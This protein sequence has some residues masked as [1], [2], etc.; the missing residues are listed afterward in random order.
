MTVNKSQ[1]RNL[2]LSATISL[3]MGATV[4]SCSDDDTT[5]TY[6]VVIS[7]TYPAEL[8]STY[9][10]ESGT[11][12]YKELNTGRTYTFELPLTEADVLPAGTYDID[13]SMKVSYTNGEGERVEQTLR[14]IASQQVI[15]A[16]AQSASL[17][18]FFYNSTNTLVF[19]EIYCAGSLNAAGTSGLY[20]TFFT[21]YNNTDEVQYAD[22]LALV[23]S[24]L[25]NASTDEIRTPA[26][27]I[28]TNF[29][30][31]TVYVIPGNGHDVAI[32]P[33]E[34]IKIV[35]QAIEWNAQVAGALDHR[36]AD[37][38]W[39]DVV[40]T[41]SVRDTDNPDV[42]NLDK[43]FSYSLT[44]WIPSNQCNRSYALVRFPEGM[45]AEKFLEEQK[46]DYKYVN[47]ATGKEMDGTKAYLI[48]YE[49]ILDGVNLCPNESWV[50]GALSTSVDASHAAISEAKSDKNRFGKKFVRKVSG[51]SAAGNTILMD[52]NDSA[53][54]FEIVSAK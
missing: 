8:P 44:I 48:K 15:S 17:K 31:Q 22:G 26:N 7:Q 21:I 36:D 27:Q 50:K 24:K 34:S 25:T 30:V 6:P 13:G 47:A 16:T 40:T 33:G 20:D 11:I 38:E 18:W 4:S 12:T 51:V 43:W 5:V 35:D 49:W 52:T 29:T 2:F 23:E 10:V 37:F 42:P 19:G 3:A 46:G 1:I 54:D 39:Y 53:Q 41:G 14:A 45:T 28:E 9:S 32:N